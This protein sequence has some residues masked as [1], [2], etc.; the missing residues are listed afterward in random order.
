[1]FTG[2]VKQT[3]KVLKISSKRKGFEIKIHSKINF[4]KKNIGTSISI[5]G[6]CLTLEKIN[7]KILLFFISY[8]TYEITNFK[9]L[10][11]N[12]IV[13]LEEPLKFGDEIAGHFVQGHIDTI[14]MISS[15]KILDK[16]WTIEI[17]IANKFSYLLLEKGSISIN[18]ISLTIVK[19]VKNKFTLVIVPHTLKMTNIIY[20]K[21]KNIVNIEFDMV[22]KYLSK[23]KK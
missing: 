20:L 7:K 1:M 10:K 15:V 3:G 13:N 17:K 4:T 16:T 22:I 2:I 11:K 6:T 14:G 19:V 23:L 8:Q 5:N 12:D 18:G 21:S 9:Y